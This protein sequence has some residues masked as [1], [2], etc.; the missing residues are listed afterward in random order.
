MPMPS[1][2]PLILAID[3]GTSS[4]RA[5]VFDANGQVVSAAQ[6]EF[7]QIYP[8]PGWVEHDPEAIWSSVDSVT[9]QAL[10]EVTAGDVAGL[11][12]TNQRETTLVWRRDTGACIHNAIVWQD[13]RTADHCRALRADGVEDMVIA[14]TGLRLDPYFSATKIAWLLDNVPG[15]RESAV[16]GELAFGTVDTFLLWRLTD[17]KVHATDATN[18]SRTL[19]FDIH[20]QCWDEDLLQIFDVPASML[21][22]VRDCAAEFGTTDPAV[23][24]AAIPV[25]GMAGDQ[26]AALIGQAGFDEGMTKSTYGTGCFVI[27][28]T[29]ANAIGSKNNLLTTVAYR[30]GGKVSYGL[31]GS[32]FVAGSAIQWLRDQLRIIDSAPQTEALARETGV[33]DHVH[34]VPAFA[35][36]GAPYWDPDARGAILGLSRDTGIGEIVT[37]TLQAIAYQTRDLSEAMA[38]DGIEP[39]VIRVDGGMVAND[40]FLQFLADTL[41]CPVERPQNVESTVLG[42]AYLAGLQAGVFESTAAIASLWSSDRV[43]EPQMD[44]AERA[45]LY[46]GWQSAVA[47]VRS[48]AD[49]A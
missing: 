39:T 46:D 20:R 22:E 15:A 48:Q 13:R 38:D 33:V 42:A 5:L 1:E 37:A 21:P 2:L 28:N 44:T 26:Q 25:R 30:L 3:Q 4:S 19:L 32:I 29:A 16:N 11:G 10:A 41:G 9:K 8:Q 24:G 31:E 14:R 47:R 36:L 49:E 7:P 12:M 35:G 18:A 45:A 40:W 23:L 17:G 43:F 27:A 34:V 6:Q